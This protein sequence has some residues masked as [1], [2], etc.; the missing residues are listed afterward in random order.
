[1]ITKCPHCS[2]LLDCPHRKGA[3]V[4]CA[5]CGKSFIAIPIHADSKHATETQKINYS[6]DAKF[7]RKAPA[8][9]S[10]G[11][12]SKCGGYMEL[13]NGYRRCSKCG[14]YDLSKY[15][16]G[17]Y[18]GTPIKPPVNITEMVYGIFGG[19]F[20]GSWALIQIT[21]GLAFM[22]GVVI[23]IIFLCVS[24]MES[25]TESLTDDQ[26]FLIQTHQ[27]N[28]IQKTLKK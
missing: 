19:I 27:L 18:S 16:S 3:T 20:K 12:C 22:L 4:E 15:A 6:V 28:Q 23:V 8:E 11:N 7:L 2:V 17:N 1:M 9:S 14:Q 5:G 10:G 21:G 13:W 25:N 24:A 26:K